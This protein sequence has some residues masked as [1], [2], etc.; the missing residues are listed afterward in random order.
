MQPGQIRRLSLMQLQ[1]T[2]YGMRSETFELD[3]VDE[4]LSLEIADA[5][6]R[7][8]N[9]FAITHYLPSAAEE[10]LLIAAR[11]VSTSLDMTRN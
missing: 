8:H 2:A 6:P 11:D 3:N 1:T 10:C 9:G 7:E 5:D 4:N